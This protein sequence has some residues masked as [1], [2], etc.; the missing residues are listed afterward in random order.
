MAIVQARDP[1]PS[2]ATAKL[3][4]HS[5]VGILVTALADFILPTL[6]WHAS[7]WRR[8]RLSAETATSLPPCLQAT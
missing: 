5:R 8:E 1:Q 4:I 3:V 7:L 6:A 2:H